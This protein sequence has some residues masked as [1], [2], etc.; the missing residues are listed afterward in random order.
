VVTA[1]KGGPLEEEVRQLK[2]NLRQWRATETSLG[3]K[4]PRLLSEL[5]P[6][7]STWRPSSLWPKA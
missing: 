4:P 3:V 2:G 1:G 7:R 5:T 6:L